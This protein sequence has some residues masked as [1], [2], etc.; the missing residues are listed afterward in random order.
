[1]ARL[2][3]PALALALAACAPAVPP[4]TAAQ[5]AQVRVVLYTTGW[6]PVCARARAWLHER[7]IPFE[8]HDVEHEPA[9]A[10]RFRQLSPS[11]VVPVIDVEGEILEG[12][13]AEEVRRAIDSRAHAGA[14]PPG[15]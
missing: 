4:A 5:R 14:A 13:V 3:L 9:A 15:A 7:S 8:E 12:F 1:M 10:T 2:V 11:R 6:C